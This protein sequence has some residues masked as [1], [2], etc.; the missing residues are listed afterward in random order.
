MLPCLPGERRSCASTRV[1]FQPIGLPCH[2]SARRCGERR[3]PVSMSKEQP[4]F[5]F[6]LIALFMAMFQGL[7]GFA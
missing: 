6:A 7:V 4:M 1:S 3:E 2:G 5:W